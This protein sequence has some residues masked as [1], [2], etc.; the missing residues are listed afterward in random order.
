M[1]FAPPI[2]YG[3]VMKLVPYVKVITIGEIREYFAKLNH[4]K[5]IWKPSWSML[6]SSSS[7]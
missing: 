2:E 7:R 5:K 6:P 4:K 3:R 1:Y